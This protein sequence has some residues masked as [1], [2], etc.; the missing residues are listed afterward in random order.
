MSTA[1]VVDVVNMIS[2]NFKPLWWSDG[3]GPQTN[4]HME[5]RL[6]AF[7]YFLSFD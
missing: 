1:C 4:I 6:R 3:D 5:N 2:G 7:D